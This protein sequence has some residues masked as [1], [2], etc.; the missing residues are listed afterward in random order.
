MGIEARPVRE[1]IVRFRLTAD[2]RALDHRFFTAMA[3]VCATVVF[4]GFAPTY[5]LRSFTARPPLPPLVHLHGA[6]S[7]GWILLFLIQATLV[8]LHR[9][10]VHR[11]LGI[12]GAVLAGVVLV[13][14]WLTAIDAARRGVAPPGAPPQPGFLAIPLG[15]VLSFAVLAAAGLWNRRRSETHKRFM[16]LATI[17]ILTPALARF[18][19]YGVG[20]GPVTAI[21]GTLALIAVCFI[22]DRWAHGRVH[23]AFAWGGA[24]LTA[25][26]IGRFALAWT[27]AWRAVG[28]WLIR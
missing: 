26:L 27:D 11:R 2:E 9:T 22:Y 1:T 20:E 6:V 5:Y 18:R 3:A 25:T 17:A 23:P 24:F 12:A 7:T 28:A 21:I 10:D 8:S 14:G 13:M 16:L 15:T 19:F 4:V